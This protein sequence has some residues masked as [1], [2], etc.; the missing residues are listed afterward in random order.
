MA[1]VAARCGLDAIQGHFNMD[2]GAVIEERAVVT[3]DR[4]MNVM[5]LVFVELIEGACV[6]KVKSEMNLLPKSFQSSHSLPSLTRG[7]LFSK[8]RSC[9]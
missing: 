6:T 3:A 2:S 1:G 9:S 7:S 4:H 8:S 5:E